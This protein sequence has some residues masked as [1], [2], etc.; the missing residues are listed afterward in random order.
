MH[1]VDAGEP[2]GVLAD[3]T[4]DYRLGFTILAIGAACGTVFWIEATPPPDPA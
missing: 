2:S 3:A 4:G 1:L